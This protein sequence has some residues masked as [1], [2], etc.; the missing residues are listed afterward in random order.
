MQE[1]IEK[2]LVMCFQLILLHHCLKI[3]LSEDINPCIERVFRN[4]RGKIKWMHTSYFVLLDAPSSSN[5]QI[6][7]ATSPEIIAKFPTTKKTHL[8][9][10]EYELLAYAID[11]TLQLGVRPTVKA[12]VALSSNY[13][14]A[15]TSLAKGEGLHV[16]KSLNGSCLQYLK[17][18]TSIVP[19]IVMD[20]IKELHD[21]QH[22]NFR[23]HA[24]KMSLTSAAY[25]HLLY[26]IFGSYDKRDTKNCFID[27][28]GSSWALDIGHVRFIEFF[29]E[30]HNALMCLSRVAGFR[31]DE[32]KCKAWH[33]IAH[34]LSDLN[35]THIEISVYQR[36]K[37]QLL[38]GVIHVQRTRSNMLTQ[39]IFRQCLDAFQFEGASRRIV[40]QTVNDCYFQQKKCAHG[41][42]PSST[43]QFHS[44][45]SKNQAVCVFDLS[46]IWAKIARVRLSNYAAIL[47]AKL[48]QC[49]MV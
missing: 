15:M 43:I 32:V 41:P 28:K 45:V 21:M 1:M 38:P 26:E 25:V 6:H 33:T 5:P 13:T 44:L 7:D 10:Q 9:D 31:L 40:L 39:S 42:L 12:Y 29:R 4:V 37:D 47:N 22:E 49:Q 20:Y 19:I 30:E 16:L 46:A 3:T 8:H 27:D 35:W 36:L 18:K 23:L 24:S 34:K 17:K 2:K 48:S 14:S 11:A